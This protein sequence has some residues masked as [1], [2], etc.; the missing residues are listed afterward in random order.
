MLRW[1]QYMGILK[2]EDEDNA[3]DNL[4]EGTIAQ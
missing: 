2:E 3:R 1:K 4:L